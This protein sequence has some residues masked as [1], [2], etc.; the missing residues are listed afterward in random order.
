MLS[1]CSPCLPPSAVHIR[2]VAVFAGISSGTGTSTSDQAA[3]TNL[4]SELK[5]GSA[6]RRCVFEARR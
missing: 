4:V 2:V 1:E 6:S 5:L 3:T